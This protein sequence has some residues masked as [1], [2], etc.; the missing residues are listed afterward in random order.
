MRH[1]FTRRINHV[2]GNAYTS[3]FCK[4][5]KSS[6]PLAAGALDTRT[7]KGTLRAMISSG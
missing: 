7:K 5:L 3:Q 6:L 2:V 1:P 4:M